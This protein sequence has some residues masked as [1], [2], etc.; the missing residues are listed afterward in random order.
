MK[1]IVKPGLTFE[2][3][4][5]LSKHTITAVKA[6]I[7]LS[8]AVSPSSKNSQIFQKYQTDLRAQ[9]N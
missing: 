8:G 3:G 4:G 1:F 2:K 7:S 6:D 5:N 9:E